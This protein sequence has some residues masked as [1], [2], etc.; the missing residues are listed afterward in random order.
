MKRKKR[1]RKIHDAI[2]VIVINAKHNTHTS[3][4][5]HIITHLYICLSIYPTYTSIGIS[6]QK[7][8]IIFT[9]HAS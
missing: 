8:S 1:E 5:H 6:V 4:R 2:T 7:L 3:P 9:S